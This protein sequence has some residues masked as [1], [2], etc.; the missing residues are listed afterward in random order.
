[1]SKI[2]LWE[3]AMLVAR[4]QLPLLGSVEAFLADVGSHPVVQMLPMTAR[5]AAESTR[6]GSN[7]PPDPVHRIIGATARC[8]GLRLM[9]ADQSIR[10]S[11]M[12]ALA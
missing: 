3:I 2:T 6:L 4:A 5:V 12:I 9:T 1:M 10:K 8:Y 11:G 7:Y